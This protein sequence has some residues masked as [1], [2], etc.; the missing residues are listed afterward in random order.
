MAPLCFVVLGFSFSYAMELTL[1]DLS[2]EDTFN[3]V[4]EGDYEQAIQYITEKTVLWTDDGGNTLLHITAENGHFEL[5]VVCLEKGAK[6]NVLNAIGRRRQDSCC[7]ALHLAARNGHSRCLEALIKRDANIEE[8]DKFLHTPLHNASWKNHLKCLKLLLENGANVDAQDVRGGTG[9]HWAALGN[10]KPLYGFHEIIQAL[11]KATADPT[12]ADKCGH[13]ALHHAAYRGF[14]ECV[15]TLIEADETT[16]SAVDYQGHTPLSRAMW[17]GKL[18]CLNVLIKYQKNLEEEMVQEWRT[19]CT[20]VKESNL[21]SIRAWFDKKLAQEKVVVILVVGDDDKEIRMQPG[22][23]SI[24]LVL[25]N[26]TET[27]TF[28]DDEKREEYSKIEDS[29]S[30]RNEPKITKRSCEFINKHIRSLYI[31]SHLYG[32]LGMRGPKV[33]NGWRNKLQRNIL[34]SLHMK[35]DLTREMAIA[36]K[37]FG[38]PALESLVDLLNDTDSSRC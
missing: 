34:I 9:L 6:I 33:L 29:K 36:A 37:R 26:D 30:F 28:L 15:R 13:L 18:D 24:S 31:L 20:A 8:R 14:L 38:I 32:I 1:E 4:S 22:F 7:T 11:L 35:D 17:A 5:M 25:K 16:V 10:D 19:I 2:R 12:I 27:E 23:T 21:E 3:A